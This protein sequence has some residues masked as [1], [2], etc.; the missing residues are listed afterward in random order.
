LVKLAEAKENKLKFALSKVATEMNVDVQLLSRWAKA[1]TP[2]I[3][4]AENQNL[5]KLHSGSQVK[6]PGGLEKYVM[7]WADE[8]RELKLKVNPRLMGIVAKQKD[9]SLKGI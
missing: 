9:A 2:A 6:L 4:I 3:H 8:R 7:H 1:E 5:Y